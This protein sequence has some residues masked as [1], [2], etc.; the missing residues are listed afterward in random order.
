MTIKVGNLLHAQKYTFGAQNACAHKRLLIFMTTKVMHIHNCTYKSLHLAHKTHAQSVT[1][2]RFLDIFE[3]HP[4]FI[5]SLLV[6]GP[7]YTSLGSTVLD[8]LVTGKCAAVHMTGE[9]GGGDRGMGGKR[10]EGT[11]S[12]LTSIPSSLPPSSL[13][14]SY[15]SSTVKLG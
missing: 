6:G 7:S 8:P 4:F 13:F 14:S 15:Y 5:G 11:Y 9:G 1:V 3:D 12:C 2:G 10:E